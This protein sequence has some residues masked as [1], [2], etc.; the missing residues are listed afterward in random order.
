[1]TM[2]LHTYRQRQFQWT[3]FR[4]NQPS[5]CWGLASTKF[6]EP[7]SCPWACPL[8]PHGQIT[9]ILH[10]YRQR[11]FQWTWFRVNQPSGC[12][13]LASTKF[14]EPSSCPWA[15]P[16]YPHG[17]MTMILHT[18]RQRQF[19]WTWFRV[20][21]PVV[22]EFRRPQ[23]SRALIMPMGMPIMPPWANDYNVG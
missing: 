2:I 6:Q 3:W 7:S 22:A 11:Q 19:Q 4:V 12:W 16:L 18:Y 23:N 8:Y 5:G 1:M 17:Q 13:G 15:C 14:Q 9:M 21:Q 20:N 10:T